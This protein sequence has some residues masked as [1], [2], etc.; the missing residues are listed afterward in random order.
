[1]PNNTTNEPMAEKNT[2]EKPDTC[3]VFLQ[4]HTKV[5]FHFLSPLKLLVDFHLCHPLLVYSSVF[6]LC[7]Q[8]EFGFQIGPR[9]LDVIPQL[10]LSKAT[11]VKHIQTY[12]VLSDF[13]AVKQHIQVNESSTL[14]VT[15]SP[16]CFARFLLLFVF[17]SLLGLTLKGIP[18]LFVCCRSLSVVVLCCFH[19]VLLFPSFFSL[20]VSFSCLLS[21]RVMMMFLDLQMVDM[22]LLSHPLSL[23][24]FPLA[25]LLMSML[26]MIFRIMMAR[27]YCF[28]SILGLQKENMISRSSP[29]QL[30]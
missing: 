1:M 12:Q 3:S 15:P 2:E 19:S 9:V 17:L 6:F 22:I 14:R 28:Y 26:M 4:P 23:H 30:I 10:T 16:S 8:K 27:S 21:L 5:F 18:R 7:E 24:L 13:Y 29:R 25:F 20:L 11:I